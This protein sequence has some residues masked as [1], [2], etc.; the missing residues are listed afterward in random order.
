MFSRIRTRAQACVSYISRTLDQGLKNAGG[1]GRAAAAAPAKEVSLR[2]SGALSYECLLA[3]DRMALSAATKYAI[4]A[5]VQTTR[6]WPV[7]FRCA[8][9]HGSILTLASCTINSSVMKTRPTCMKINK[10]QTEELTVGTADATVATAAA[11]APAS[12]ASGKH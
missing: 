10:S 3:S 1:R 7:G 12:V 6:A 2:W 9:A 8:L 4:P 5:T 11:F